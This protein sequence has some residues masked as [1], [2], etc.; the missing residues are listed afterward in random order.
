M[1]SRRR[2]LVATDHERYPS[3]ALDH[4]RAVAGPGGEVVLAS[5]V[6]V[7][8]AQPLDATLERDV[9]SACGVLDQAEQ[10]AGA[11]PG[12]FDTRLVRARSFSEGVLQTLAAEPFDTVVLEKS[13]SAVGNGSGGGQIQALMER[14][15]ATVVLVRTA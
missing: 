4:A 2:V 1:S 9:T 15:N 6:V 5:V 7:P 3:A 11:A 14:A 10:G 13:R 12:A 8:L